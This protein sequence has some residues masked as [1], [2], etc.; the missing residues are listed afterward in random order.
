MTSE[1]KDILSKAFR[2][3]RAEEE[4]DLDR[5]AY[6]NDAAIATFMEALSLDPNMVEAWIGLGISYAYWPN[7]FEDALSAFTRAQQINPANADAY[8]Q[9]G[10]LYFYHA[11]THHETVGAEEYETA[12]HY[13]QEAAARGYHDL[14]DLYNLMGT[15]YFRLKRYD[16]AIRCFEQSVVEANEGAWLPSTYFLAAE[17]NKLKGNL[18]E[19]LRWYESY[20]SSGFDDEE[21]GLNIR[22]LKIILQNR[23]KAL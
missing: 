20:V 7:R 9:L 12:L 1:A 2:I 11:E 18:G 4:F 3:L 19:A 5:F 22:N 16:E 10:R 13:L 6:R 23:H 21:V 8:Y 17:A 15:A 14:G